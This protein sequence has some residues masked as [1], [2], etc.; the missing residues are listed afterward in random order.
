MDI[1][2]FRNDPLWIINNRDEPFILFFDE[3]NNPRTFRLTE[4]GFNSDTRDFFILGGIGFKN[5][6]AL[7]NVS[8]DKLFEEFKL[9]QNST[10]IKF[11]HIRRGAENFIDLMKSDRVRIFIEWLLDNKLVIHYSFTDNLYYSIVDIVDSLDDSA[12]MN[13][14]FNREVKNSLYLLAKENQTTFVKL[15]IEFDYPNIK[16]HRLFIE[17]VV[18]WI[19][20]VNINDDF[21]LEYFRQVLKSYRT[22]ELPFLK[23]N[24]DDILIGD[25]SLLYWR[26]LSIFKNA[27]SK[28]DHE[29]NIEKYLK[30]DPLTSN[31]K[32]LENYLFEDS[33]NDKFIQLSDLILGILRYWLSFLDGRS[34]EEISNVFGQ[35][36]YEEKLSLYKLQRVMNQSLNISNGF[37]HGIGS[38]DIEKKI[39]FFLEYDFNV[40]KGNVSNN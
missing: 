6:K 38:N 34:V 14:G 28:L 18:D 21:Y 22:K 31:R 23:D 4:K 26:S 40:D 9:Q 37:K 24:Q 32:K 7:K 12:I 36:A 20:S 15:L 19:E 1:D 30:K 5:E 2:T 11:K 13:W 29:F 33:K 17:K 35:V 16:S 10:E 25:Y 8:T 27:T 3:T 39:N